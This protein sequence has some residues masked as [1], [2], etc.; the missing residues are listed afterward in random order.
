[1]E[2]LTYLGPGRILTSLRRLTICFALWKDSA[3][4]SFGRHQ[5]T[6]VNS[7]ERPSKRMI[8][9]VRFDSL[10]ASLRRTRPGCVARALILASENMSLGLPRTPGAGRRNH[11]LARSFSQK[12]QA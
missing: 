12:V 3:L 6:H 7:A 10:I 2:N 1:M 9:V 5:R 11:Q 4:G 8:G